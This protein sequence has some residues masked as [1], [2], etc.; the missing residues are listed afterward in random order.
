VIDKDQDLRLSKSELKAVI[1]AY[2]IAM[3]E[4]E[5][6]LLFEEADPHSFGYIS[7]EEYLRIMRCI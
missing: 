7:Y 5:L 6:D 1:D 4:N 2:K 3:D